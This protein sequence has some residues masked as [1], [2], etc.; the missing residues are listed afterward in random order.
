M[1]TSSKMSCPLTPPKMKATSQRGAKH[2]TR[3]ATWRGHPTRLPESGGA[4]TV[5]T[6]LYNERND[7]VITQV[8]QRTEKRADRGLRV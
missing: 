6:M 8:N 5:R 4:R 2:D 1:C 7:R 3:L